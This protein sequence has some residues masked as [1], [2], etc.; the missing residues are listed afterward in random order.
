MADTTN[1]KVLSVIA[2]TGSRLSELAIK[3][4]QMIFVHDKQRIAFD[5]DGKRK[6]YNQIEIIK[7]EFERQGL[8]APVNGLFYFVISTSVLWTYQDDHWIQITTSPEDIVFIG[9]SMPELGSDR[10]LYVDKNN[11]N[12][13]VWNEETRSYDVVADKTNE[14]TNE[15]ID[16][17]F[18]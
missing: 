5:Y 17:L 11:K 4:G 9:V 15:D 13:S 10:T 6:F 7:T 2:T 3:D 18:L 8:L 1:K 12:I 14:I 16:K